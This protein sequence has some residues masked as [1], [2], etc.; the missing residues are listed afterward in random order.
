M[1]KSKVTIDQLQAMDNPPEERLVLVGGRVAKT[2]K[3]S[4]EQLAAAR[5]QTAK[6][7]TDEE[8]EPGDDAAPQRFRMVGYSGAPVKRW[9][10]D[11]VLAL[12][13]M[14]N[15]GLPMPALLNHDASDVSGVIDSF[16]V[17]D[18]GLVE[19][20]RFISSDSGDKVKS[21]M[22]QDVPYKASV[23]VQCLK[24]AYLDE[25]LTLE[26]NG[27]EITGPATIWLETEV[28]ETS[29]TVIPADSNTS[30]D[31]M[32]AHQPIQEATMPNPKK[33]ED[34]QTAV[35][36]VDGNAALDN[37]SGSQDDPVKEPVTDVQ[38]GL[39]GE[40][41]LAM[42]VRG[43]KLGL[44]LEEVKELAKDNKTAE[45]LG[46]AI[47]DKA[48]EKS[49]PAA[50]IITGQ[51]FD[52]GADESERFNHAVAD[53]MLLSAGHKFGEDKPAEGAA[54]FRRMG[55]QQ[56]L[57][58]CLHA[59][60]DSRAFRYSPA[61]LADNI[62]G[63]KSGLGR[64]QARES[65]GYG[66]ASSTGDFAFIIG[67][68]LHRRLMTAYT[69]TPSTWQA[70]VNSGTVK[71][72]REVFGI[73]LSEAP[74]LLPVKENGEYREGGL[75]DKQE[76]YAV[77]K[78][79][80]ILSLTFEMIVNDDLRALLRI[81]QLMGAAAS[82]LESDMVY[83]KLLSNPTM[84]E[85]AKTLFHVDHSNLLDGS[86]ISTAAM[87]AGFEAMMMQRGF[88]DE[89]GQ[90]PDKKGVTEGA[91]LGFIPRFLLVPP[92][93]KSTAEVLIRSTSKPESSNAGVYNVYQND[94]EPIVEPRLQVPGIGGSSKNWFL[95][96]DPSQVDT[97]EA[98]Y[99]EGHETPLTTTY[100][101]FERDAVSWKIR[102]IFGVGAMD[103]RGL[104]KN[105][106]QE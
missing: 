96:A 65:F 25:D 77:S 11:L 57:R 5:D 48:A 10:G 50:G 12:D 53:G 33:P 55:L 61:E 69:E 35:E 52:M 74:D 99:L 103:W 16:D 31:I 23:G 101:P 27:M 13:G 8:D 49:A 59:M 51:S 45:K 98:G 26:I 67:S 62:L 41:M 1:P 97:L 72:F 84:N 42:A 4:A 30:V 14:S 46:L 86:V 38:D 105:P 15:T 43:E 2:E 85:D 95:S 76:F 80:R 66:Q 47:I 104:S 91:L 87:D 21:E 24:A 6:L 70:W 92:A 28:Y 63:M 22:A 75:K 106:G 29:F 32:S 73:A 7:A 83:R 78:S 100:E 39:S 56:I 37:P 102:H 89:A 64:D 90:Y 19:E 3:R 60:G 93:L 94:L 82:R 17:T 36:Q 71:D 34:G 44:R 81:P 58:E 68:V 9:Y 79:G 18:D 88:N 54:D 20:G 40:D